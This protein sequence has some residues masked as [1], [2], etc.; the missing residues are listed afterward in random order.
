MDDGTPGPRTP[1]LRTPDGA[2]ADGGA[3]AAAPSKADSAFAASRPRPPGPGDPLLVGPFRTV[4]VLAD[5]GPCRV[6]LARSVHG[7][8]L[9]V[10]AVRP[11]YAGAEGVRARLRSLLG[12]PDA[13]G[14][15][16][17]AEREGGGADEDPPWLAYA[18][19]PGIGLAETVAAA[20]PLAEPAL[21]ALASG[22]LSALAAAHAADR[23]HLALTPS[24]VLL[25]AGGPV[26]PD[27]GGS[28]R[29]VLRSLGMPETEPTAFR[30]PETLTGSDPRPRPGPVA[31]V[32]AL[33]A[34]LLWAATGRHHQP[35]S[36]PR[37]H[38]VPSGLRPLI[39]GCLRDEPD[40]R[41]SAA[42]AARRLAPWAPSYGAWL[43][44]PLLAEVLWRAEY[45]ATAEPV[46]PTRRRPTAAATATAEP[47]D[48][49]GARPT[50]RRHPARR[51]LL[52]AG[53][54]AAV[55]AGG[56]GALWAAFAP[57]RPKW[58]FAAGDGLW[59]PVVADP[60]TGTVFAIDGS[61]RLYAVD[62]STGEGLWDRQG[63]RPPGRR[64]DHGMGRIVVSM[65]EDL[66]ALDARLGTR[67]WIV[68]G[69]G[70]ADVVC[71]GTRAFAFVHERDGETVNELSALDL[72]TGRVRWD[73][74]HAAAFA[75]GATLHRG[76]LLYSTGPLVMCKD[77]ATGRPRWQAYVEGLSDA[78]PVGSGDLVWTVSRN[79][80]I[81][82][83]ALAD[84]SVR[85]RA[86]SSGSGDLSG[87]SRPAVAGG[88]LVACTTAYEV[89]AVDVATG[90]PLWTV[91]TPHDADRSDG[92][93]TSPLIHR[94]T[95]LTGTG[96]PT[97]LALDLHTGA[98]RWRFVAPRPVDSSPARI[99]DLLYFGCF[100]RGLYAVDT[101]HGP[102]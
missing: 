49:P 95:V 83:L 22:L 75:D 57:D 64:F 16:G 43:P 79:G 41:P 99:G 2:T 71:D 26:L 33:G 18:H 76:T 51:R 10:K 23:T 52:I 38:G 20:G 102:E 8:A 50:T 46:L 93:Q 59:E 32:Y 44:V 13:A 7:R 86:A 62:A 77:A 21:R 53:G 78:A 68:P 45:A 42:W 14:H 94:N 55:A 27:F 92:I 28:V 73:A 74:R 69:L 24:A 85:V 67:L 19:R 4:A 97:V 60:D 70:T 91:N 82:G 25:T 40:R 63:T 56:G 29:S 65:D 89:C 48:A 88:V 17:I 61:H 34:V 5:Q 72:T 84:G 9:T 1:N 37:L 12:G 101:R 98:E 80:D 39:A 66:L 6:L 100:D 96:G 31:D 87:T 54:A 35:G 3:G 58:R 11:E 30:A 47:V 81:F 15:P 90:R 36:G